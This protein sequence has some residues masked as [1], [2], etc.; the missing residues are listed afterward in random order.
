MS[1]VINNLLVELSFNSNT[2]KSRIKDENRVNKQNEEKFNTSKKVLG[3][4]EKRHI[5]LY[6]M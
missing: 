5:K 6:S 2:F 1:N 3:L 4:N